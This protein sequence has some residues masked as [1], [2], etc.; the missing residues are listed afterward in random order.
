LESGPSGGAR[1]GADAEASGPGAGA[2]GARERVLGRILFGVPLFERV[3]LQR[4]VQ[5]CSKW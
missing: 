3:K 5:K 2:A 4:F 1:E